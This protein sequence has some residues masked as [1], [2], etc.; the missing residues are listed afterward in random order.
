M[1]PHFCLLFSSFVCFSKATLSH[2]T[3]HVS[4]ENSFHGIWVSEYFI[5][6]SI[7]ITHFQWNL[8]QDVRSW[9]KTW[10]NFHS[11]FFTFTSRFQLHTGSHS[12]PFLS[13]SSP[14]PYSWPHSSCFILENCIY[15]AKRAGLGREPL[16][17]LSSLWSL[18]SRLS[19]LLA[20]W[21][22]G[23]EVCS[24]WRMKKIL[25]TLAKLSP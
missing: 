22:V 11:G 5:P 3:L 9:L 19:I 8:K 14:G 13:P 6:K 1:I 15:L 24:Q 16:S 21:R 7:K 12:V 2:D 10:V 17:S 20:S 18:T 25:V 4:T 23:Q